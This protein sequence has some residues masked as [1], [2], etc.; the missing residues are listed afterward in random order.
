MLQ[1]VLLA[2]TLCCLPAPQQAGTADPVQAKIAE[3]E[4]RHQEDIKNDVESGRKY[5][6][7]VEKEL[8][9]LE[10]KAALERVQRI[11]AQLSEIANKNAL[12]V[13]WGDKR[14]NTFP[15]TFKVVQGDD[16][17]AFSLPGGYIYIY[18]GLLKFAESDDELAGVLGHEICH[19][20]FR[21]LATLQR[22]QNK[23]QV[24]QIP[25]ILAAIL[26]GGRIGPEILQ[27]SNLVGTALN[28]GWSV[29]AEQAA[30]FGGFQ[31]MRASSYNPVGM[32]TF[33]ERLAKRD[34]MI[35]GAFDW[36]IYRTHPPGRERADALIARLKE[37]NIVIRRS[38][39]ST[40]FRVTSKPNAEATIDI[41][42]EGR[43]LARLGGASA[44]ERADA[45][46]LKLN[47]FLDSVPAVFE[48]QS[49]GN[50]VLGGRQW[51][52]S[53]EPQDALAQ[54]RTEADLM[55]EAIQ[56]IRR[57]VYNVNYRVWDSRPTK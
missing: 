22:E 10:D 23:L 40:T 49:S 14:L 8:K 32:L 26:S 16:V 21:H 41:L 42:F 46:V 13:S 47:E 3:Q 44:Q 54:G 19:A 36:G 53:I 50:R 9:L 37:A 31:L 30:D 7:Q 43:S 24:A 57:A 6:E 17:N 52:F 1:S 12:K 56:A 11:G 2:A 5:A 29:K 48:V 25:L 51:L 4:R 38:Q 45:A 27:L 35:E 20:A 34:R 39:V 18:E 15:Y 55:T 33:M 28:S